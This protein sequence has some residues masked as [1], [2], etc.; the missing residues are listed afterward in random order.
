ME[1]YSI[2]FSTTPNLDLDDIG[3][4]PMLD[5][6]KGSYSPAGDSKSATG[7]QETQID[8]SG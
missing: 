6:V 4:G 5:E 7:N 1:L 3:T 2:T 8:R